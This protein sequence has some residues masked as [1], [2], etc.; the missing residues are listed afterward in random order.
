VTA[1]AA[2]STPGRRADAARRGAAPDSPAPAPLDATP[3]DARGERAALVVWALLVVLA[4]LRAA[5]AFT[6]SMWGWGPG[7]LRFIPPGVGV[8]LWLLAALGLVPGVAR[9]LEPAFARAGDA[10][11][12]SSRVATLAWSAA[13]VLTVALL[14]DRAWYLGDF[15]LRQ[16]S[17]A[18]RE[19]DSSMFVQAGPLDLLLHYTLP[20]RVTDALPL[21][22]NAVARWIGALEAALLAWLAVRF[23]RALG[24][25]GTAATAAA[26]VV[27]CGGYLGVFTGYG[28]AFSEM[29]VLTAAVGAFGL[30]V[31]RE[32]RGL[33]PLGIAVALGLTLHRSALGFL[34][35]LALAWAT[36]LAHARRAGTLG[37]SLR[38][39]AVLAGL[40]VPL[41]TLAWMAPGLLATLTGY[42]ARVHYATP[43]VRAGGG[44]LQSALAGLRPLDLANLFLMLSPASL[45]LLAA[46]LPRGRAGVRPPGLPLLLALAVPF[47]VALPLVVHPGQG[48][49][50]DWD[51]FAA[52]GVALSL[53]VAWIAVSVIAG[54][55]LRRWV[56][57]S[58]ALAALSSTLAWLVHHANPVRGPARVEAFVT[59]APH[60]SGPERGLVWEYLGMIRLEREQ[61]EPASQALARAAENSPSPAILR[62]WALAEAQA[63]RPAEAQRIYRRL[64]AR[65]PDNIGAWYSLAAVSTQV[66]DYAAARH[67]LEQVLRLDPGNTAAPGLLEQINLHHPPR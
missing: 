65:D 45:I 66:D 52:T 51:D 50:R 39:P 36:W 12:R 46:A 29:A 3:R 31:V 24:A 26:A 47:V 63:G 64:L 18:V 54:A 11:A 21:D 20:R 32:R 19:A 14:P 4:L 8:A 2:G 42:D 22:A 13:A 27:L 41:G 7:V 59:E 40:A 58:L 15:L 44:V 43:E 6:H 56:G 17:V 10:I 61:W 9:R 49:F 62:S 67:A 60:R 28:K 5:L 1:R 35:A 38:S 25:R 33:L 48:I 34:P 30:Q 23:A 53:V 55:G 57:V 16:G 37:R